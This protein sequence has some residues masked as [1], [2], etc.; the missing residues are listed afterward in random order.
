MNNVINY[1]FRSIFK[2]S[3]ILFFAG[4]VFSSCNDNKLEIEQNFPFEVNVM[5][6]PSGIKEHQ[7]VEIRIS[8]QTASIYSGTTYS[9]RYFQYQGNGKLQYNDDPP[10][11]PNDEYALPQKQFRLYYTSESAESHKF[12]IWITDNFGNE[13]QIDF[14]FDHSD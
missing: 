11:L 9:I 1:N 7:T 4:I 5:P 12:S 8:L 2:Y 14:E 13:K 10:Y 6:V 3:L